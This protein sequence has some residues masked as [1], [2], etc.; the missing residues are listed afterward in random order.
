MVSTVVL[1]RLLSKDE[2]GLV[3]TGMSCF[4]NYATRHY[5][6]LAG[7]P[8]PNY[9]RPPAVKK[10]ISI[11]FFHCRKPTQSMW[12]GVGRRSLW[13]S[14]HIAAPAATT[15]P[16]GCQRRFA[17]VALSPMKRMT[18]HTRVSRHAALGV[19]AYG[20]KFPILANL[21]HPRLFARVVC[22]HAI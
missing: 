17:F 4:E 1:T 5:L 9:C 20:P 10:Q 6:F 11:N 15:L 7:K 21:A 16:S 2:F 14:R 19:V 22:S 13:H 3:T 18:P 8:L 12:W